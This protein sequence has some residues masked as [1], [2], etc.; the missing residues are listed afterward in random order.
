MEE[1][2]EF[3]LSRMESLHTKLYYKNSYGNTEG[4]VFERL[5]DTIR[6]EQ[7]K[8]VVRMN[9]DWNNEEMSRELSSR[10]T[11]KRSL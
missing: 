6:Y 2:K 10:I 5:K 7:L 1:L 8:E 3:I 11:K 9:P 4:G